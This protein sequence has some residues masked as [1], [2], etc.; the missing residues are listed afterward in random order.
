MKNK[1]FIFVMLVF[2]IGCSDIPTTRDDSS[3]NESKKRGDRI[4]SALAAYRADNSVY[5]ENLELLVPKYIPKID[6]PASG[7]KS[8]IYKTYENGQMY[9][10]GFKGNTPTEPECR[11]NSKENYWECDKK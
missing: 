10:L 8:W 6:P 9:N 3:V 1:I 2:I 4:T 11:F 7:N 5:P